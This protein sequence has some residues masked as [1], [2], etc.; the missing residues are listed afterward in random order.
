M[1]KQV[2]LPRPF[3]SHKGNFGRVLTIGGNENY[4]GAILMSS[5]AAV[6][7]GAGLVSCATDTKNLTALH[8]I[9][10][11][12]MFINYQNDVELVNAVDAANVLVIGPGLG[13]D[14]TALKI[15]Q[16]VI[17]NTNTKQ[18]IIVDG[19]AITL[20]AQ[21]PALLEIL[22]TRKTIYTPHQMEWQRL[23][24]IEISKQNNIKNAL[25]QQELEATVVLKKYHTTIYHTD[26]SASQLEVGGPY[27]STGGMGD[28]L[29]GI[30]A[31]FL[32]QFHFKNYE[33]VVD[34]AVYA[35]SALGQ[36]LAASKYVV[37]PTD[38]INHLQHFMSN[39]VQSTIQ[40]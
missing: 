16:K 15:L 25:K 37:L 11:E 8:S 18:F 34:A 14:A 26:G 23:S 1:L 39:Y 38:I 6:H 31:A 40:K 17:S 5:S 32:G 12:A 4:G 35:H 36:E 13:T 29:T 21:E 3:K 22:A 24:G 33:H 10:P 19:S 9:V 7:A 27:M 20:A 2:I 28:T 30:I